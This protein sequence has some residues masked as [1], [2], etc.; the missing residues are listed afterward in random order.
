MTNNGTKIA[1]SQVLKELLIEY[2]PLMSIDGSTGR[3]T[4]FPV[5]DLFARDYLQFAEHELLQL[6]NDSSKIEHIHLINC[7]SHL[8]RAIDCQLDVCLHA[9]NIKVFKEK[10]LSFNA[11]L[12][13]FKAAGV[14]NSFSLNRFNTIRNKM[15]HHYQIPK[16]EDIETYFDFVSAFVSVLESMITM[17]SNFSEV[18][19]V[20]EYGKKRDV[21]AIRYDFD[22]IPKITYSITK[23]SLNYS[24]EDYRNASF[25]ISKYP[26]SEEEEEEQVTV[27]S[28]ERDEFPYFLKV[29]LLLA[30]KDSFA[31]DKYILNHLDEL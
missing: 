12:K 11:K 24:Y 3:S 30:R 22:D 5:F 20:H 15:E 7:V 1:K 2:L 18:I 25:D 26:K 16:I 28:E 29:L 13:F 23:Q 19:L 6:K 31:S 4:S 17:F 21:F 8:K 27:T 14:F 9:L 10:N